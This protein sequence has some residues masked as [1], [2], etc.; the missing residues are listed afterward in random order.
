MPSWPNQCDYKD[1]LQN[2]DLAFDDPVLQASRAER[3]PMGIPRARAGAFAAVYKMTGPKGVIALKLFNFPNP[4]RASRYQ[5]ISDYLKSLGPRKPAT[6]VG[7]QYHTE[8]IRVGKGWYPT[9][10]MDWVKGQSLGEWVREAMTQRSPNLAAVRAMADAWVQLVQEIQQAQIAHGDLQHDNVMVVGQQLVLVDYDGMCVPALDP[11]PPLPKLEQLEFGKPAYQHP[12]RSTQKLG[13][14]LDHFAAWVI[15]IALRACAADPT[16]YTRY[17]LKTNN[18]NL[19]FTPQDITTPTSSTLWPELLR[20]PDLEVRDWARELR[21]SLD[22]PFEQIPPFVLDPYHRLRKL[23]SAASR[24][25]TAIAVETKRLTDAG[26][27]IPPDLAAAGDPLV[28]L[29]ELCQSARLDYPAIAREAEAL[30]RAGKP[31]P[32]DL[33][34]VALDAARRVS[35]RD[36]VQKALAAKDPRGVKAVFQKPLLEGWVDRQLI[37]NAEAAVAQVE[38]L[39]RLRTAAAAPGDGR[40]LVSLWKSVGFKVSGLPEAEEYECTARS[41]EQRLDAMTAFVR[42]YDSGRATEREL[43]AAWERVLAVGLHPALT[44]NHRL[45]GE[46]AMRWAPLLARLAQIPTAVNYAND[47]ARVAIWGDG[48]ALLGCAE[49]NQYH[50]QVNAARER[51]NKVAALKRAID[52]ADAG[53]GSELAIVEAART[54]GGYDHPYVARVKL[55]LKSVEMLA[56]LRAAVEEKP[57]SDRKIA[58]AVDLLRTTNLELLGRLHRFDPALAAEASAAGRRRKALDEFAQIAQKYSRPDAQDL[59]WLKLWNQ[60]KALLHGRR[61]T[62]E[63]RGRLTLAV[64]R[65]QAWTALQKALNAGDLLRLRELYTAH[66]ELLRDYPPLVRRLPELT[67][68]LAKANRVVAITEKLAASNSLPS[69]DELHFLREHHAEFGTQTKQA[70]VARVTARLQIDAKLQ[71][72]QPPLRILT[73]GRPS[74]VAASWVWPGHGLVSYCLVGVDSKRHLTVPADAD[75]YNLLPCRYEDYTRA[76]GQRV[77]A[78]PPLADRVF[79]TVWAVV[80]LGWT[81]VHGPPL[82]LGPVAVASSLPTH[83]HREL[84]EG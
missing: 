24:D 7:F 22:K 37:T 74:T 17:V 1:A 65:T 4:D 57:P 43:A 32:A 52:A 71:P 31:L 83:A 54:L 63:L 33:N 25:W 49:A 77:V 28:R 27:V 11:R 3:S 16:L 70:I 8:G 64:H 5:A 12:A 72:G 61:D 40:Q 10:T 58:A 38:I 34:R 21:A 19:L 2:P 30:A 36:A 66:A 18:E 73:T 82:H 67:D 42:L 41:W 68:L 39:D 80:D 44:R 48:R 9:L 69:E 55:A 20:C 26:R 59:R 50:A 62:E 84:Q 78:A 13:L 45:R 46:Q 15:L 29:R 75:P 6:L 53:N 47:S 76:G 81:T 60:H 79:V 51:L 56:A 23:V 14:H 35:C